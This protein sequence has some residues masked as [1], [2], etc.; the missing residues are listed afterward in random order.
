M[1]GVQR[2]YESPLAGDASQQAVLTKSLTS[3]DLQTAE[4]VSAWLWTMW[5]PRGGV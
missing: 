1:H 2:L 5:V 4:G 3:E